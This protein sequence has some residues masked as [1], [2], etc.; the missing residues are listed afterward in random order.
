MLA[1]MAA[2]QATYVRYSMRP[3]FFSESIHFTQRA[4]P[5]MRH[6]GIPPSGLVVQECHHVASLDT[7]STLR[8][9]DLPLGER[10]PRGDRWAVAGGTF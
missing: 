2:S 1:V 4:L 9:N 6:N 7:D 5:M 10:R 3:E 8:W